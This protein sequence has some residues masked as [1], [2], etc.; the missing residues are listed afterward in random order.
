MVV[1]CIAFSDMLPVF[2]AQFHVGAERQ[3]AENQEEAG[4]APFDPA[5]LHPVSLAVFVGYPSLFERQPIDADTA[6]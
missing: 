6:M 5:Q 4:D 2:V 3:Q 1:F